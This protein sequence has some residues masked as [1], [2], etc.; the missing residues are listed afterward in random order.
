MAD[1]ESK[2]GK[3]RPYWLPFLFAII[4]FA[5]LTFFFFN[6]DFVERTPYSF[7]TWVTIGYLVIVFMFIWL[8]I[9]KITLNTDVAPEPVVT[10]TEPPKKKKRPKPKPPIEEDEGEEDE[11]SKPPTK[12]RKKRVVV[13]PGKAAADSAD[14]MPDGL[15]RSEDTIDEDILDLSRVVEYPDKEPGG[16]YSDTPVRV[17]EH[18]ILNF[19]ILLGKVCHNC[20]ELE[21]CKRRV[22]GKLDED[23]FLYNFECK[24][25]IKHELQIA[26]KK[27]ETDG[28]K[29]ET[30]KD[31]VKEK[32]AKAKEEEGEVE[33]TDEGETPTEKEEPKKKAPHKKKKTV[34]KGGKKKASSASSK[35]KS[36]AKK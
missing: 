18:L 4:M 6:P 8:L 10:P 20:E 26:R 15:H 16:V 29:A 3:D 35:K 33:P 13:A 27:R 19:R 36:P 14:E 5:A 23:V 25:G 12:P 9:W 7:T 17:D 1:G 28:D 32:A 21:E 31:M 30:A 22:E 11:P 24:D 34:S 2:Q